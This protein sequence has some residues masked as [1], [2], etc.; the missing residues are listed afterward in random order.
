MM[1]QQMED[2]DGVGNDDDEDDCCNRWRFSQHVGPKLSAPLLSPETNDEDLLDISKMV[3]VTTMVV[4]VIILFLIAL[5]KICFFFQNLEILL[6]SK[7]LFGNAKTFV[8]D[9]NPISLL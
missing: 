2:L 6:S 4:L 1:M 8:F 5:E 9:I 7:N 3:R